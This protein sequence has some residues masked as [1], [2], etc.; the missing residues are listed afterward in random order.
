[1]AERKKYSITDAIDFVTSGN[2]SDLSDLSDDENESNGSVDSIVTRDMLNTQI[3][4]QDDDVANSFDDNNSDSDE[5][6]NVTLAELVKGKDN[7]S[8][9][10][11]SKQHLL[12]FHM[13]IAILN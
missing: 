9:D 1:M 4:D 2:I 10:N 11:I 3:G 8:S 13:W 7:I 12:E 6:V 5:D